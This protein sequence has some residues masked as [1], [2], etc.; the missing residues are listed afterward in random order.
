ME[1]TKNKKNEKPRMSKTIALIFIILM[2]GSSLIAIIEIFFQPSTKVEIPSNRIIKYRLEEPQLKE[3]IKNYK[4]TIEYEYPSNCIECGK[5]LSSL[6]SWVTNSD[7]QIYLQEIEVKSSS[8]SKMIITSLK[9]QKILYDPTLDEAR[10][11]I[12]EILISRPLFCLE[13]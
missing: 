12:C 5:L 2:M 1:K 9:G 4:T 13:V 10:D 11:D 6:E 3:L 7:D 8:S